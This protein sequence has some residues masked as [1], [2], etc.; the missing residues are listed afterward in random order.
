MLLKDFPNEGLK[1]GDL[2]AIIIVYTDPHEAYEVEF[3]NF[4]GETRAELAVLP[5]EIEKYEK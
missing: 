3:V 5:G 4:N 1:S 2:G